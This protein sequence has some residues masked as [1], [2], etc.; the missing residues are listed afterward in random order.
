MVVP[1]PVNSPFHRQILEQINSLNLTNT[2]Q[3]TINMPIPDTNFDQPRIHPLAV[4]SAP[5]PNPSSRPAPPT[6][7][8]APRTNISN[9]GP[10]TPRFTENRHM[11][12]YRRFL[13]R[14]NARAGGYYGE[15]RPHTPSRANAFGD[16]DLF[17]TPRESRQQEDGPVLTLGLGHATDHFGQP[18]SSRHTNAFN[19][20]NL[21]VVDQSLAQH[22]NLT[23]ADRIAN[24]Q[25]N[26]GNITAQAYGQ[27]RQNNEDPHSLN[28]NSDP[29]VEITRDE[30]LNALQNRVTGLQEELQIEALRGFQTGMY[31]SLQGVLETWLEELHQRE[32]GAATT[33]NQTSMATAPSWP[34]PAPPP[35]VFTIAVLGLGLND[36]M[37]YLE[38]LIERFQAMRHMLQQL[39]ETEER[40]DLADELTFR[41]KELRRLRIMTRDAA[42][43]T[44][45]RTPFR[46]AH[47]ARPSPWLPSSQPR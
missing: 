43:E 32:E 5:I 42:G 7:P 45:G 27:M 35:G 29:E 39:D 28:S 37:T 26:W 36:Q 38:D 24:N 15:P 1:Q 19:N 23:I 18:R 22:P 20:P 10:A 25:R 2:E 16:P 17:Q 6:A 30:G 33:P 14:N 40:R 46:S 12:G 21:F 11:A 31:E 3:P 47:R 44:A 41:I 8:A 13:E 34:T 4:G 9:P